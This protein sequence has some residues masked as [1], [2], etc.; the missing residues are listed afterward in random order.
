MR[1]VIS[2]LKMKSKVMRTPPS[3]DI[4]W[5]CKQTVDSIEF[6]CPS[7]DKIQPLREMDEF[8]RLSLKPQ[9]ELNL[10]QLEKTY[11]KLQ[12]RLHP[13]VFMSASELEKGFSR[14]HSAALNKAYTVLKDPLKRG[15]LLLQIQGFSL[16]NE[17]GMNLDDPGLLIEMMEMRETLEEAESVIALTQVSNQTHHMFQEGLEKLKMYFVKK[18]YSPALKE[19]QR[20]K[21]VSNIMHECCVR[22]KKVI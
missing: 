4:C 14:L 12:R 11:F 17:K 6:L 21:Y 13:D 5:S 9:F 3:Q 22:L 16:S 7:C 18:E 1:R 15:E 2:G 19:L 8:K 20:L 10:D